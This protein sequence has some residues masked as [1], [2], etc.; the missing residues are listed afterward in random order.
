MLASTRKTLKTVWLTLALPVLSLPGAA[1]AH[2]DNYIEG[3]FIDR[4]LEGRDDSGV[5]IAGSGQVHRQLALI[6]EYVDTGQLEQMGLGGRVFGPLQRDL[7]WTAA[8]TIEFVDVGRE[9]DTG[10]GLRGGLRWRFARAFE[11]SPEIVHF[12]AFDEG[13]TSLRIAGSFAFDRNLAIQAALQG[14]DDD[15]I[16]AGIRYR[17]APGSLR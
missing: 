11:L 12:D 16:E 4:D 8:A 9:D 17:F 5:R 15:R 7:D 13:F 3:G 1:L 14:G 10:Y 2:S 6:G